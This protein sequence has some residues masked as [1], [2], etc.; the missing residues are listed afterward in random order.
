M[1]NLIEDLRNLFPS[2]LADQMGEAASAGK[3]A[4]RGAAVISSFALFIIAACAAGGSVSAVVM[5]GCAIGLSA[6]GLALAINGV[7]KNRSTVVKVLL[8]ASAVVSIGQMLFGTLALTGAISAVATGWI[9]ILPAL[10]I[11][12]VATVVGCFC[13][14]VVCVAVLADQSSRYT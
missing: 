6:P 1:S 5:G 4:L 8:C 10:S 12:G 14:P 3:N 7:C 9:F 2:A 13:A 11:L